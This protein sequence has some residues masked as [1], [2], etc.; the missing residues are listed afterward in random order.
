[1]GTLHPSRRPETPGM[2]AVITWTPR[3]ASPIDLA[4]LAAFV[5]LT[6]ALVLLG[7][8]LKRERAKG[9]RP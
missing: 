2:M 4:L 7:Y 5:A 3:L 1:M 8:L 6:L 9:D